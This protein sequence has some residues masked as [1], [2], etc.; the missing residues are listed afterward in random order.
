M[1]AI[2]AGI[3]LFKKEKGTSWFF[4]VHPGGPYW[5]GKETG[6]WSI[7]KGLVDPGEDPMAAAVR[8]FREETGITLAG[9][10]IPLTPLKQKSGKLV[11]AWALEQDVDEKNIKSNFFEMEWPPGSGKKEKFPEI[12]KGSWF[13]KDAA[14]KM[15]LPG[16]M[17]FIDE[18][19]TKITPER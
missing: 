9:K 4:L 6:A 18:L 14:K 19:A 8:E 11:M 2:S 17:A 13:N 12:D 3:L 15:I 16:Q 7:P 1:A 10:Y 5:K